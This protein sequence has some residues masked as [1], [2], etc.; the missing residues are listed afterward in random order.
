MLDPFCDI[1]TNETLFIPDDVDLAK[2]I[3]MQSM[4][5][6]NPEETIL[7]ETRE[8]FYKPKE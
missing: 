8:T 2:W 7:K 6:D 5:I 3:S 4:Y 1:A